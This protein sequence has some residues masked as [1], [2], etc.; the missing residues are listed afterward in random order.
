MK[1]LPLLLPGF[2]L[3][4][5][6]SRVRRSTSTLSRLHTY[7]LKQNL[8]QAAREAIKPIFK[9][10]AKTE[11]L[12]KCLEG[13][14]QNANESTNDLIRKCC[15][16][17]KNHG[18][19][20][21]STA[22]AMAV[23]EFNDGS[24]TFTG[25]MRDLEQ[26]VGEFAVERFEDKDI[27]R[28]QNTQRRAQHATHEARRARRLPRLARDEQQVEREGFPY[29]TRGCYGLSCRLFFLF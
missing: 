4:T 3:A 7:K 27:R 11:L 1:I 12:R 6:R 10:L 5:F 20:T 24:V 17:K 28:I 25:I 16:Q 15:P 29:H 22:L 21:A 23:G 9:D 18:L 13:Y 8:P 14:N 2:E 19:V 26:N